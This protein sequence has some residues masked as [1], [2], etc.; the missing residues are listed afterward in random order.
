MLTYAIEL[1][2]YISESISTLDDVYFIFLQCVWW[3]KVLQISKGPV[4]I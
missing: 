2:D 3:P 4:R 1:W